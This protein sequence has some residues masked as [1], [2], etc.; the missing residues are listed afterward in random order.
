MHIT[1]NGKSEEIQIDTVLALLESKDIEP[2]MVS[3]ELNEKMVDREAYEAT[4]L[5]D[6]DK[7]EFLFFMGGGALNQSRINK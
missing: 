7:L 4:R 2:Q 5:N 1:I 6:G 3:V